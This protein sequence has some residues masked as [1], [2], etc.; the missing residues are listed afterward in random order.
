M[1]FKH[2]LGTAFSAMALAAA[3]HA[4]DAPWVTPMKCG[5][6]QARL[7]VSCTKARS[8][9]ERNS[10]KMPQ[11]LEF[12]DKNGAVIKTQNVPLYAPGEQAKYTAAGT[13]KKMFAVYYSCIKLD[14]KDFFSLYYAADTGNEETNEQENEFAANGDLITDQTLSLRIGRA[15]AENPDRNKDHHINA[16][17]FP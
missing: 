14:G 12:L 9:D 8:S 1:Q 4:A 11:K 13:D 17:S 16:V 3:A 6:A 7:T 15:D 5:E 10:C 2:V